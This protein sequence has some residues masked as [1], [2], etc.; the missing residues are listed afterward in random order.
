MIANASVVIT[1]QSTCTFVAAG[2]GKEV[3]TNLNMDELRRLM[4]IQN[5]GDSSRR[6]ANICRELLHT[7]LPEVEL[8][9]RRF[10][11]RPLWEDAGF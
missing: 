9:R 7:P 10:R 3:H 5:G 6:I 1:Q 2:L 8:A 11:P 4:P